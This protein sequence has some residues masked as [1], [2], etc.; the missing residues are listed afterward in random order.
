[1]YSRAGLLE[2]HTRAHRSYAMVLDHLASLPSG[3]LV[4]PVEGFG[5]STIRAQMSHI[6][7]AEL[8]WVSK[9]L[10]EEPDGWEDENLNSVDDLRR[11]FMRVAV[12]TKEYIEELAENEVNERHTLEFP[13]GSF[14]STSRLVLLRVVTHGFHHQGQVAAMFRL[15]GHP[16]DDSDLVIGIR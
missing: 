6:A 5:F 13:N 9:L 10:D 12:D 14:D 7:G 8:F 1:M 2:I 16:M 3:M 15:L 11:I 4:K